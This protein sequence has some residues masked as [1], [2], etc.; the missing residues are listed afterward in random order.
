MR[1][2][3]IALRQ[4]IRQM[5]SEVGLDKNSLYEMAK[6]VLQEEI[7]KQVKNALN[8]NNVD[9]I[10]RSKVSSYELKELL[11]Q[12]IKAEVKDVINISVEVKAEIPKNE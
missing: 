3:E 5:L 6:E 9:S 4:E 10:I 12:A 8:Q 2:E 7:A 1:V 11:R